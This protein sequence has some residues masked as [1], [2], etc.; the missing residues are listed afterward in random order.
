M[1]L[2]S[3]ESWIRT[4]EA[5]VMTSVMTA[6]PDVRGAEL[7]VNLLKTYNFV[8]VYKILITLKLQK[9]IAGLILYENAM[10]CTE[11]RSS[12]GLTHS[13]EMVRPHIRPILSYTVFEETT[14]VN[15]YGRKILYLYSIGQSRANQGLLID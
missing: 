7:F 9:S 2:R 1:H 15:I 5:K 6:V 8:S 10:L 3:H 11:F 14:A 4:Q 12:S 13:V